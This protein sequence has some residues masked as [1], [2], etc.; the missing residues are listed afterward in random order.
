MKKASPKKPIAFAFD[1]KLKIP[2]AQTAD[3]TI[4]RLLPLE[5]IKAARENLQR[6]LTLPEQQVARKAIPLML[7]DKRPAVVANLGVQTRPQNKAIEARVEFLRRWAHWKQRTNELS[8]AIT[9]FPNSTL[10]G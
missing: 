7:N 1:E 9:I 10:I 3:G 5:D 4:M 2:T 8:I 6:M